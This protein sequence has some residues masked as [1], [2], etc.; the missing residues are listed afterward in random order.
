MYFIID[1][2]TR[3]LIRRSDT[4]FNID[5]NVQPPDPL[6]QLKQVNDDTQ[7][8]YDP[9]TQRLVRVSTDNDAA[10]TRTFSWSVEALS[11]E[12]IDLKAAIAADEVTLTTTIKN[13]YI[14]LR[15]GTGTDA[16]RLRR[17]EIA[18]A[19]LLRQLYRSK[20]Q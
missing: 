17:C 20:I 3:E 2:N 12:E 7:P 5:E 9:A 16:A 6:I 11:Q 1:K 15:D 19:F 13:G 10:F 8:A 18:I 14:A 4:P